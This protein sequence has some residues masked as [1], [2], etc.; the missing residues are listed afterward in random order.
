MASRG[1]P[2]RQSVF[3]SLDRAV[4]DL[5]QVGGLPLPAEAEGIWE[6]IWHEETHHSTAI[7]G[8]TLILKQV[9]VLLEEGKAVGSKD[10]REYLEV[11][12]YSDAALWVY[13]QASRDGSDWRPGDF[14][15]VTELR[16][17]HR[18]VVEPAWRHSPPSG[19]DPN[20]GPGAFRQHDIR[21]FSGGMTP[22]AWPEVPALVT[23]WIDAANGPV[24][25]DRHLMEHLA[26]L[27]ADFECVHPFRDGNGRV[28]R[29]ALNLLLVRHGYPPAIVY[30]RDRTRYLK[31]LDRAD[32]GDPGSLAELLARAVRDSIHRLLLPGLAGPHRLVPI[33]AL[34]DRQLSPNALLLAA[35]RDRLRAVRQSDQWYSTQAWVEDYRASRYK[36]TG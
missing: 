32:H 1:R 17:I 27:H 13:R 18:L 7:E 34:G 19:L 21:A 15:N 33:R 16:E 10:L 4:E 36:R 2:S 26:A 31:A 3:D 23:D 22:P 6:G 25:S 24:P 5:D 8:N 20:E 12:G 9:Q 29:L 28:G 30:K 35:K 11:Q 14:V